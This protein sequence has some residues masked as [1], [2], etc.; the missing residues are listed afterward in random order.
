[1]RTRF[2][3]ACARLRLP[4]LWA[5]GALLVGSLLGGPA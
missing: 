4:L 1:M 3:T 2:P 5:A